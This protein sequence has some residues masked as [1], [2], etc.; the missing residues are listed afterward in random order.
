MYDIIFVIV[1]GLI[2]Y[3]HVKLIK[4]RSRIKIIVKYIYK[5]FY[6]NY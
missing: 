6:I 5:N 1:F 3:D 4:N 2:F